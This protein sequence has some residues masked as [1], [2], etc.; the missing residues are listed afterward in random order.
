MKDVPAVSAKTILSR[1]DNQHPGAGK[2][3]R[4]RM[5]GQGPIVWAKLLK[6]L[7]DL[8]L[9]SDNFMDGLKDL[10]DKLLKKK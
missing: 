5:K 7:L 2:L 4:T 1:I 9:N 10:L 6:L 3:I 8:M